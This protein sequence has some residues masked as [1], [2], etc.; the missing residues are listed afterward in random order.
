MCSQRCEIL[1]SQMNSGVPTP[2]AFSKYGDAMVIMI[3]EKM[4]NR[5]NWVVVSHCTVFIESLN[6]C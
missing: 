2:N 6:Y 5:M 1:A 4:T 3:A